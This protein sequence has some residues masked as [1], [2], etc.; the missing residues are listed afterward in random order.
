MKVEIKITEEQKRKIFEAFWFDHSMYYA[1]VGYWGNC[2]LNIVGSYAP[3]WNLN[4]PE[5]AEEITDETPNEFSWVSS[6]GNEHLVKGDVYTYT[7]KRHGLVNGSQKWLVNFLKD[8]EVSAYK[9]SKLHWNWWETLDDHKEEDTF[10]DWTSRNGI[11]KVRDGFYQ[12]EYGEIEPVGEHVSTSGVWD[13]Y[14]AFGQKISIQGK[15]LL[16]Q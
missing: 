10:S 7:G 5:E 1:H 11:K 3:K 15:Y 16:I 12:S 6:G 14:I 8:N 4:H 13:T 9:S 2:G